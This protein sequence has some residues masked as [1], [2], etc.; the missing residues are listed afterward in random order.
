MSS[1]GQS[2][3]LLRHQEDGFVVDKEAF[4]D[5]LCQ[6]DLL[7]RKLVVF[8]IVGEYRRGKSFFLNFVMRYLMNQVRLDIIFL[9]SIHMT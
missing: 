3:P 7:D 8:S 4:R 9:N 1:V 2:L 5:I 6:S